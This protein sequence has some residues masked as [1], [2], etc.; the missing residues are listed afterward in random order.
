MGTNSVAA[1]GS[2][3]VRPSEPKRKS[4]WWFWLLIIVLASV[5]AYRYFPQETQG[6]TKG[7]EKSE[8]APGKRAGQTVPVVAATTRKG[9]LG[10]YLT[11]L[12]SVTAY[13]TVT[14][15]SRIDGELITVAFTEGQLVQ[16]GDLL[17]EIDPRPYEA[18]LLQAEGQLARD[19][20]QLENAKVDQ[21]RY[22]VLSSQGVIARQ[23]LDTQNASV[24]QFEGAIKADQGTIENIKLQLIYSHIHAPLTGRI[25]LRLVD[26]GNIVHANDATGMATITQLQ[27]IAVLFNLAQDY[28]PEVMKRFRAGQALP[29][30]A[31]DRDLKKKL[32]V[33]KLLTIDNAIDPSTG[34][35]RFKAE[36]PNDDSSL[37]PNQF[38]NARLLVDVKHGVAIV[39]AAAVQRSPQGAFVYVVTEDQTAEMRPIVAGPVEGD[40]ASIESG[41]KA[42]EIVVVDGVDKLQQGSKVEA[43]LLGGPTSASKKGK[44]K[45]DGK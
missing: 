6:A 45:P 42:G 35:A 4:R 39:P 32:A 38:V 5:A 3:T 30:E 23:Q 29:V 37:F 9:D 22:D 20:A 27:P 19:T 41:L 34:T 17:A 31:W 2:P 33:G 40:D 21:K 11:G 16:Q 18:Q 28:L 25:G 12:G 15:R 44:T 7:S 36:F 10:I 14:I 43:R 26:R 13:N 1:P 24:H 8:K